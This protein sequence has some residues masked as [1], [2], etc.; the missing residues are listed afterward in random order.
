MI[1]LKQWMEM[2]NYRITEGSDYNWNCY[3]A[4]SYCL[5]SWNGDNFGHSFSITFDTKTQE[6]YEVQAHDYK[7]ERAYRIINPAYLQKHANEAKYMEVDM[8]NAWE[9]VN[10]VDLE[11]DDDFLN[12]G[13]AIINDEEYD[14]RV[15]V[16]L[17]L[18][19]DAMFEL[20][21]AAHEADMTLNDYVE[22]IL[23]KAIDDKSS[24][25][26]N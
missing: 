20:M 4:D 14:T 1:T 9:F 3:G 24:M 23:K 6:V 5:D 18:D 26:G 7:N 19:N 12:K 10:Y 11:T 2:V 13:H 17:T 8:N 15:E 16:P 25:A 22:M 21:K